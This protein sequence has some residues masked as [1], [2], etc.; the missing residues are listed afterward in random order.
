MTDLDLAY[1][2][3]YCEENVWHLC[4]DPR[5]GEERWVLFVS[6]LGM[7]VAMWK[8]RAAAAPDAP[9][10]WDYHVVV[11]ARRDRSWRVWD[12]DCLLGLDLA[13]ETWLR[14]SFE[15]ATTPAELWPLFR[16]IEADVFRRTF[17]SDRR[18]MLRPDGTP[19]APAPSWPRIGQ[20]HNLHRFIDM[21]DT[22]VPGFVVDLGGLRARFED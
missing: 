6:N 9:V 7:N 15:P 10:V 4:A 13:L 16:C 19:C 22:S 18:H 20:G 17:A 14:A 5:V 8:Q 2:P 11:L 12:L 21:S 1:C 3:Y